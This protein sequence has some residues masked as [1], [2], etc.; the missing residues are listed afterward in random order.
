MTR[1][2]ALLLSLGII[3]GA[4]LLWWQVVPRVLASELAPNGDARILVRELQASPFSLEGVM[5]VSEKIYRCEYYPKQ[6]WP[7]FSACSF[8]ADSYNAKKIRI[9]WRDAYIAEV[10]IDDAITFECNRSQWR[11]ITV[12]NKRR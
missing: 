2:R 3:G 9:T 6:G 5:R 8:T 10:A 7:M 12:D 11:Q 4:L 1:V